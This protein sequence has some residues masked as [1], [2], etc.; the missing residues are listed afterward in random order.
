M[1]PALALFN[2]VL[3]L[4]LAI[5]IFKLLAVQKR[6]TATQHFL[7]EQTDKYNTDIKKCSDY[8]KELKRRPHRSHEAVDRRRRHRQ[9]SPLLAPR[10]GILSTIPHQTAMKNGG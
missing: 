6:H 3:A 1:L 2:A 10:P 5:L 4:S 9:R 8:S 7:F